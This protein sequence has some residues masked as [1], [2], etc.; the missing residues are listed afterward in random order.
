MYVTEAWGNFPGHFLE[1]LP[2][3][4]Q[5]LSGLSFFVQSVNACISKVKKQ[6]TKTKTGKKR[7]L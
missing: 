5:G 6:N 7:R 4:P 1:L 3:S 2:F